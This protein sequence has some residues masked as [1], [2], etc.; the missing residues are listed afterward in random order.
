MNP[1][2]FR[3]TVNSK[4]LAITRIQTTIP[5][6]SDRFQN[7]FFSIICVSVSNGNGIRNKKKSKRY[8]TSITDLKTTGF[9]ISA[10]TGKKMF[11]IINWHILINMTVFLGNSVT[12]KKKLARRKQPA[13]S[14]VTFRN[15]SNNH[16][17]R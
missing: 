5:T 12:F 2:P 7:F 16:H 4:D 8:R 14:N 17:F 9:S 3:L 11:S 15:C 1:L 10:H 13:S 6:N